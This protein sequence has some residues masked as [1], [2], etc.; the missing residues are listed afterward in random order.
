MSRTLV[1]HEQQLMRIFSDDYVFSIPGYQRPYSWT[2]EQAGELIDDIYGF[3]RSTDRNLAEMP[4][5]FLG[6]IVL[7][8]Q[9]AL[10]KAVVVD[11]QQRL[12]TITL[13]LSAIREKVTDEKARSGVT[14]L[15]YEQ[16]D[17]ILNTE[18]H[19]R[20]SLRERDRHFFREFVQ[21]EGGIGMLVKKTEK[22]PDS[23]NNLRENAT[24]FLSRLDN[25][26]EDDRVRLAQ[27]IATRCYL[28]TVCTPDLESAFRIF[29]VLN[30]RGL[31]LGATDI[32]KAEII[33]G[34]S[35]DKRDRYTAV[36]EDIEDD[37]G[38][39]EFGNLFSHIRMMFRKSKQQG[40]LLKEFHD[41]VKYSSGESFI[42]EML[43][44]LA[45]AYEEIIDAG[46]T[47]RQDAERIN[48]HLY[49]LSRIEFRDWMP[50]A[51]A[52]L[53]RCRNDSGQVLKFFRDLERLVYSM[54][55][56][57]WGINQRVER[58]SSLTAAVE[59]GSDLWQDGS[60]LMNT[61]GEQW[62]TYEALS[63]PLYETHSARALS[64][65]LLRLDS[66]V[67]GGGASY[68]FDTVTVEHVLPQ[69]PH[70]DGM[71]IQWFPVPAAR[72]SWVHRIGNLALLTRKKNSSAGNYEFPKKKESYFTKGGVS[73]FALTTQ[74][75]T[76]SEWTPEIVARRQSEL[77]SV[78]ETHFGLESRKDP[79]V[80]AFE[81]L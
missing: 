60:P 8:K 48:T 17:I 65:L 15:I 57:R 39:E 69:N 19:Y 14:K 49:W 50:P 4:P 41:H 1:A 79:L 58:C 44:P 35:P 63:G 18:N 56:Q 20:L 61:P 45:N 40:T 2:T 55:I 28:V 68:S 47:S 53:L 30:S 81:T 52:F 59:S 7:I 32:L 42:D 67:S 64:V 78:L 72:V 31:D 16:G 36:W 9:E 77:L 37:L 29:N 21:H 25:L 73:P 54:L 3:M 12:T 70:P 43:I 80:S 22:L 13:L 5:Y 74:V 71:W 23:Q 66:L 38:R 10:P 33:G 51:L 34:I 6:S 11:G 75:L 27:F 24:L 46:F 76:H 26:P 62:S